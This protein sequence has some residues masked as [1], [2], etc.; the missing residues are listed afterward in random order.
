MYELFGANVYL[1]KT[2]GSYFLVVPGANGVKGC[3]ALG[4]LLPIPSGY[5]SLVPTIPLSAK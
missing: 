4:A 2:T 5:P 3:F 1:D